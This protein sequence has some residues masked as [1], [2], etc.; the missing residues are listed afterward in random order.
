MASGSDLLSFISFLRLF[1]WTRFI[2]LS[3]KNIKMPTRHSN[4]P[5]SH[6]QSVFPGTCP[7]HSV[8]QKNSRAQN[9]LHAHP[10]ARCLLQVHGACRHTTGAAVATR[11]H[12]STRPRPEGN[13]IDSLLLVV[14]PGPGAPS[15]VLAPLGHQSTMGLNTGKRHFSQDHPDCGAAFTWSGR[16]GLLEPRR[17]LLRLCDFVS[18]Q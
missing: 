12:Q 13:R 2:G 1:L 3:H 14:R 5:S 4:A 18:T 17:S 7:L 11:R 9:H 15:S 8:C 16:Q 10:S 6:V